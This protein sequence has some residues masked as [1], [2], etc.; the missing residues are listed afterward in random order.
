MTKDRIELLIVD[1]DQ[2]FRLGLVTALASY[3]D[4][5]I[6]AQANNLSDALLKLDEGLQPDILVLE[7]G[8]ERLLGKKDV[9]WEL[10]QKLRQKHGDLPILLLSSYLEPKILRTLKT[11]GVQGYCNKGTDIDTVARAIHRLAGGETYW[12]EIKLPADN[13]WLKKLSRLSRTGQREIKVTLEEINNQLKNNSLSILDRLF[14]SGRKRELL[15]ADWLV[16]HLISEQISTSI[17]NQNQQFPGSPALVPKDTPNQSCLLSAYEVVT[18]LEKE[19]SVNAQIFRRVFTAIELEATNRTNV[20]LE[21]DILQISKRKEL[22]YL[23]LSRLYKLVQS[24]QKE[25]SRLSIEDNLHEIWQSASV[26]FFFGHYGGTIVITEEQFLEIIEQEAFIVQRNIFNQIYFAS[27][28]LAYLLEKKPLIVDFTSYRYDSP[29]AQDR[30]QTLIEN[31]IILVAN[32]ILQVFLNNFYN[33]EIFKYNLYHP[34]YRSTRE[35][36]RF[37]NDLSWRYRQ[38]KYWDDPNNIFSSRYRL[39]I[40]QQNG[41][42]TFFVYASRTEELNQ[43][44]GLPWLATMIIEIRDAISPRLRALIASLGKGMVYLLTQ[45]IGKGIGLIGKGIIQ[46]IGSSLQDTNYG[47]KNQD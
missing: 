8:L 36:A 14:L 10:C 35:I 1:R 16:N 2:I 6:I 29:E 15:A 7:L 24:L 44:R 20:T 11:L 32:A 39:L 21:I 19:Q 45:V 9:T 46:G 26:D 27:D 23:V 41:I 4:F 12:Q 42:Q 37:R 25:P 5:Y 18:E 33:L 30:A 34:K 17:V 40:L 28:L 3:P 22:L 47:K 43:L 31:L 13:F 38:E